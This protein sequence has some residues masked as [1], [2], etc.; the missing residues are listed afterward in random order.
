MPVLDLTAPTAEQCL[1]AAQ[2]I[3]QLRQ[4]G[5]VLVCCA[6]GYSRSAT[7]VALRE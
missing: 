2:K 7:A 1:D 3:E 5:P 4:H 6:L